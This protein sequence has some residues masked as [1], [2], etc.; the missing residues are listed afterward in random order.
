MAE[1]LTDPRFAHLD[2]PAERDWL[3]KLEPSDIVRNAHRFYDFMREEG[4]PVDSYT[5]EL[6]FGK[7]AEDLGIPYDVFYDAWLNERPA[8]TPIPTDPRE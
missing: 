7:A 3:T 2:D 1:H 4:I 8:A 5:R 6:A